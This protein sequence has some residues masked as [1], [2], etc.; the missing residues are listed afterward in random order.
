MLNVT[1]SLVYDTP[2]MKSLVAVAPTLKPALRKVADFILRNPLRSATLNIDEIAAA[3]GASTAA[4]NRLAHAIDLS[5]FTGLRAALVENLLGLIS[6]T[7]K[8]RHELLQRP[9][10]AFALELQV[11]VVK[12]NMD[13]TLAANADATFSAMADALVNAHRVYT[14][15]FGSGHF[16]AGLAACAFS[17]VCHHAQCVSSEGG[18]EASAYRLAGI[19]PQDALLAISLPPYSDDALALA[20]YALGRKAAI[21]AITD[22]PASPLSRVAS[23]TLY[24]PA[25]H[26]V[27]NECTA[28]TVGIIEALAATIRHRCEGKASQAMRQAQEAL[29]SLRIPAGKAT[30][31]ER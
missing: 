27:L 30:A 14:L 4:V 11:R 1:G 29:N 7:D 16:L 5:G 23:L 3:T 18:S 15:G 20:R 17:P 9:G 13:A 2:V 31:S 19:G 24:G 22:S 25:N 12:G 6:P 8:V 26:P 21:L 28:S 10:R